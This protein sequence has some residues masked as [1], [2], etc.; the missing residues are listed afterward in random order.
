MRLPTD[1]GSKAKKK[2]KLGV[3][4]GSNERHFSHRDWQLPANIG[5]VILPSTEADEEHRQVHKFQAKQK[6]KSQSIH[7]SAHE[8]TT[9]LCTAL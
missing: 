1:S 4:N 8:C 2:K 7:F 5:V 6:S 3:K 9:L